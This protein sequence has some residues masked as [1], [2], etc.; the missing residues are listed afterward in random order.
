MKLALAPLNPTVGDLQHNRVLIEGAVRDAVR[1]G[2][3]L[4]VLPELVM[5]GYPPRDLLLQG[6]FVDDVMRTVE[7]IASGVPDGLTVLIGTPWREGS[8]AMLTNSV[9]VA[10]G[11]PRAGGIVERYDKRLLPN[12]DVFDELR[13]FRPGERPVVIEVAGVKIGLAVCEDL[14]RGVDAHSDLRYA[15]APDPMA[16]LKA[17]GAQLVAVPSASP[18]VRGKSVLQGKI[19]AQQCERL[20]IAIASVNQCG[21]N[22]DLIF[23]GHCAL[24][25]PGP[26]GAL[27]SATGRPF[28]TGSVVTEFEPE[29]EPVALD[30]DPF[31]QADPVGLLWD[32]LVLGVKDYCRKSGF[33]KITLG[34]SGGIDSA[35][36]AVLAGA[37]VGAENLTGIAMPSRYSSAGSLTDAEELCRRLGCGYAVRSIEGGHDA[38][39]GDLDETLRA[40]GVEQGAAG[41]TD[42][43]IQSR[44]RGLTMMAVSNATGALLLTTGNKCEHATGYSTLYGDQ[45]GGL[46]PIADLLKGEVYELARWINEHPERGGFDGPPIPESTISKP[47]SAE[48]RPDQKDTDSLPDYAVLDEIVS[49]YVDGQEDGRLIEGDLVG[50]GV[51]ERDELRR[52]VRLIDLNEYKRFQLAIALKVKPVAFGR[53]RR[54]AIV[55]RYRPFD[56]S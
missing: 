53:G 54:R 29:G 26:F 35:L 25:T 6:G 56:Q 5:T 48:L 47:P 23:D 12:Y 43:N 20:G 13:Y 15:N 52:I 2:V 17:A 32:A 39:S 51:I 38:L 42:E 18:F 41:L 11:G 19:I 31:E 16:D 9:V 10:R 49:R 45:N 37:A 7:R 4:L 8:G 36:C 21:A 34:V 3:Q 24:Y 44:L 55:Q 22:D 14:W 33:S 30:N 1:G 46:A 40:I 50:R 28:E 27:L